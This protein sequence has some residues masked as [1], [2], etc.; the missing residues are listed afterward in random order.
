MLLPGVIV[1]AGVK[2]S[3]QGQSLLWMRSPGIIARAELKRSQQA[4]SLLWMR[5]AT[6]PTFLRAVVS[7]SGNSTSKASSKAITDSTMSSESAPSS[8]R[9]ASRSTLD[10]STS[11]WSETTSATLAMV[12]D[13]ASAALMATNVRERSGLELA[14]PPDAKLWAGA[15]IANLTAA[16]AA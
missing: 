8:V 9:V 10:L 6:S 7:S 16:H 14:M 3:Q 12:S 5:S 11:S 13:D 1:R 4:Q 2:L 15:Y